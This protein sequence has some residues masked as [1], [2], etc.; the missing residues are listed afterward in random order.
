M[1]PESERCTLCPRACGVRRGPESGA[2]FCG[3]G[4]LP[5][6]A[7]AAPHFWEEPCISGSSGSGAVFFSGCTL[8]CVYCQ[9]YDISAGGRGKR[10]TVERL[11]EIYRELEAVGVHN[12]NL[13][14]PT[15]FVPAILESFQIYRPKVPVVYNS[16]GYERLDTLRR[17]EGWGDVYLPDLKYASAEKAGRYS[18]A[19][20]YFAHASAA[21]AEMA[22][23]TGPAVFDGDGLLRRGTVVR[24][25]IL[26]ENTNDSIRLLKW[27]DE[28][29]SDRVLVSLMG[30]YLPCGRAAE[31]PELARRITRREYR[32]V[33]DVLCQLR[34]D[35]FVQQ[36]SSA[37]KDYIP[38]F[39]L[40]GVEHPGT[41][42][43][44]A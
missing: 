23:Q 44:E 27:L 22:R 4:T 8:R 16:S 1:L 33:E 10:I 3:M 29:L 26:P 9:N 19:P 15:H 13:V 12:I 17:L 37:R 34:L 40:E 5:V 18:A 38:A 7:R 11:A 28:Q 31:F 35:G 32:K 2:G 6:V 41:S 42:D 43:E 30:Q 21:V 14:N 24:H 39:D 36:L 25:L 20:D